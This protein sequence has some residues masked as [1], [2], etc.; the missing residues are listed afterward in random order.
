MPNQVAQ[1]LWA[2]WIELICISVERWPVLIQEQIQQVRK[3]KEAYVSC[4]KG[5]GSILE[6]GLHLPL[7]SKE[8]RSLGKGGKSGEELHTG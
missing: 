1:C 2:W 8:E 5:W 4:G 3:P 6:Q 7:D